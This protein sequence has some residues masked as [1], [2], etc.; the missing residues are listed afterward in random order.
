MISRLKI[1]YHFWAVIVHIR[2]LEVNL[3]HKFDKESLNWYNLSYRHTLIVFE[4]INVLFI[5]SNV[6]LA[7]LAVM[8]WLLA[9]EGEEF[10]VCASSALSLRTNNFF[11]RF[12]ANKGRSLDNF[13]SKIIFTYAC[14]ETLVIF[15][16]VTWSLERDWLVSVPSDCLFVQ[17]LPAAKMF[18]LKETRRNWSLRS[19]MKTGTGTYW[20]LCRAQ[21]LTYCI[22]EIMVKW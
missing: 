15:G 9:V 14:D 6:N 18:S 16:H 13:F 4:R 21:L 20:S 1:F 12:S 10:G 22:M 19:V 5:H 7:M 8:T 17:W 3:V 2:R 11:R